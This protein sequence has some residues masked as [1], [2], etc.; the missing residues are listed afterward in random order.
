MPQKTTPKKFQKKI[1]KSCQKRHAPRGISA[2]RR[3][4]HGGKR[5]TAFSIETKPRAGKSSK[6]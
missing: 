6:S 1:F 4:T 2:K 5:S 3:K